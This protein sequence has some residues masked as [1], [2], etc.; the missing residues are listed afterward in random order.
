MNRLYQK[1]VHMSST[2]HLKAVEMWCNIDLPRSDH[3]STSSTEVNIAKVKKM[4]TEN[5]HLSL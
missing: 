5:R 3:P 4:V 1:H 2:A